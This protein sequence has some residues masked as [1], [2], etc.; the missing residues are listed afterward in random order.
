MV[1]AFTKFGGLTGVTAATLPP[2]PSTLRLVKPLH[3]SPYSANSLQGSTFAYE[4]AGNFLR[5]N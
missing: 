2:S 1:L 4:D 5:I 3:A